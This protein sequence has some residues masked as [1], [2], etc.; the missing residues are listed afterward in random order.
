MR[1]NVAESNDSDTAEKSVMWPPSLDDEKIDVVSASRRFGSENWVPSGRHEP[2]YTDLL[3]GFG[4]SV[5]STRGICTSFTDRPIAHAN[6]MR[7]QLD[8]E[9]RFNLHSPRSMMPSSLSLGLESNLKGSVQGGNISYQ[10]QG[11]VRYGGFDDYTIVHGHRVDH[12]HGNWFMPP[13][14]S[15][16][17]DNPAHSRELTSKSVLGQKYEAVKPKDGDC[18]LFGYS[19]ISPEPAVSRR[20]I[21]D[22]ASGQTDLIPNQSHTFEFDQKSEQ[23]RGSKLADNPVSGKDQERSLQTNQQNSRELQGKTQ[24]GSTRSCTKVLFLTSFYFL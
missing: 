18:K 15:P 4:G 24:N 6:S 1:G 7:K 12:P 3:S 2:T 16:H 22:K 20:S 8:Q 14:S 17:L 19:L 9:G 10:G 13:P 21:V 11:N 5:D 23:A